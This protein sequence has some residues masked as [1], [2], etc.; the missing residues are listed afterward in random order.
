MNHPPEL[1][2][3]FTSSDERKGKEKGRREGKKK[4]KQ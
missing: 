3:L 4:N 2:D 1:T